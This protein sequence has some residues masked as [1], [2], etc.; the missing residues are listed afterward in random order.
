V[1]ETAQFESI[2]VTYTG[3]RN[4]VEQD[5]RALGC[6]VGVRCSNDG[7]HIHYAWTYHA[8]VASVDTPGAEEEA[9]A[10]L[11]AVLWST[12]EYTRDR[13]WELA[14]KIPFFRTPAGEAI[15]LEQLR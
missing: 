9:R 5:G 3:I 4:V 10:A 13:A 8:R 14:G 6:P 15:D 1:F 11:A 7:A 2:A 12:S